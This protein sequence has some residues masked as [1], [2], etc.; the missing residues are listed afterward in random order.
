M[1][2]KS[3][4][5]L[6]LCI[7]VIGILLTVGV[8][9]WHSWAPGLIPDKTSSTPYEPPEDAPAGST[10]KILL[11]D[12]AIANLQLNAKPVVAETFWKSIKVPGIVVDRPGRSD[13]DIVSTIIGVVTKIYFFPG[14]TVQTG[15]ALFKIRLLSEAM[16][17]AQSELFKATQEVKI[18]EAQ[19]K[20]LNA[21][22]GAIPEARIIE[23][24]S[25]LTRLEVATKAYRRELQNRG[26]TQNQI[27]GVVEGEFVNEI[28]IT[29]PEQAADTKPLTTPS[30]ISDAGGGPNQSSP[31]FEIQ[32]L[33]VELGQQVQAGQTLCLLSNHQML[34]IEGRAFRDETVLLERSVKEGWPVEIDFQEGASADWPPLNQEFRIW[35]LA[36]TIDPD[37]RTFAFMIRL[38]NQSRTVKEEGRTQM[39]WRFRPG[40]KVRILV[41]VEKLENV[42]VLPTDAVVREG[43][44]A[45][46]FTQNVNM[47]NRKPIRVISQDRQHT[48]IAN[49]GSLLS[50][51]FVVQNAAAQ[52]N[53]MAKS[54]TSTTP[55]GYHIHADGSLHKNS[56]E[57]K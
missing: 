13:R 47:F 1:S 2:V 53:R 10:E 9:T 7:G 48:V 26:L 30:D 28:T 56:D 46:V 35:H 36:N 6:I 3:W 22:T 54:Q 39:L 42:F 51:S 16:H 20:R 11:S 5:K 18:V 32:E 49:D 34:A 37:N 12:Q 44:E 21:A 17:Q 38:E 25:Q 45:F 41:R 14:D 27:E 4:M 15:E 43:A 52:L 19:R 8:L 24:E 31:T 50:G 40:Q 33:K 57:G 29:A 23:V 55:K